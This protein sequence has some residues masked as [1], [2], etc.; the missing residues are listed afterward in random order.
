MRKMKCISLYQPWAHLVV[1]GAKM[2]ETRC[3][4]TKCR[5]E[6]LI[7]AGKNDGYVM[8]M[9]Q[10]EFFKKH[11]PSKNILHFGAIIGTVK[12]INVYPSSEIFEKLTKAG[13][14]GELAFGDY[15]AGRYAWQLE[16]P[17]MFERP[18]FYRGMQ[19]LFDVPFELV[20]DEV[21]TSN[22]L[23]A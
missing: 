10:N 9:L 5:G 23:C 13:N 19:R 3:W 7:H 12:I 21:K 8:D 1:I 17:K 14:S 15:R 20:E 2:Y 6:V 11:V 4:S 22:L 18:I 16:E